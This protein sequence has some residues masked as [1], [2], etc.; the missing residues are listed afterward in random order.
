M[1]YG[2]PADAYRLQSVKICGTM[3]L[4]DRDLAAE[5]GAD[6]FGV[7][8]D[9]GYSVRSLSLDQAKPLF[10]SPP[11]PG[12]VSLYG[13]SITRVREVVEQLNPFAV[14]LLGHEPP[15]TLASLKSVL[16]CEVWKSLHVPA[17]NR[18]TIDVE[19]MKA[20]AEEYEDSGADSILF[21]TVDTSGG[22]TRFSTGMIG[23]WSLIRGLVAGRAVPAF[24]AG[25]LDTGNVISAI[26]AVKPEGIDVCSGVEISPGRKCPQKLATFFE[27]IA[28]F[29]ATRE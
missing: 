16:A 9:V 26:Q 6:Y 1:P 12:I 10:E 17:R 15:E 25:G 7:L 28:P 8:V 27:A 13:R 21:T 29:R 23:D 2:F 4:A 5:A 22:T 11:V 19:A 24:L 14:Q 20:L 3:S 18:G